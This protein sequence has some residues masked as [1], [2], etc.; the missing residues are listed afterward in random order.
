MK[1]IGFLS[2]GYWTPSPQSQAQNA[3]DVLLQSIDLAVESERL[4]V[5]GQA[6]PLETRP[7]SPGL[8]GLTLTLN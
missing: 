7:G 3:A 1:K 2:F 5:D 4:G 8:A 6:A